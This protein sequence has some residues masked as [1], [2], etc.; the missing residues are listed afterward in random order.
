MPPSDRT[1]VQ[2]WIAKVD[3]RDKALAASEQFTMDT[4]TAISKSA[5]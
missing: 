2:P 3:A 5:R 1:L 4:L